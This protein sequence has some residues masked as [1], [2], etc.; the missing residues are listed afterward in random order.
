[1]ETRWLIICPMIWR[2]VNDNSG[3]FSDPHLE[4]EAEEE[5]GMDIRT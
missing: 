3:G 2:P 1:M 4:S 5:V